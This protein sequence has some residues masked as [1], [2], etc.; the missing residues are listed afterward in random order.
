VS[1]AVLVP[2]D[3]SVERPS[4]TPTH[5]EEPARQQATKQKPQS[6]VAVPGMTHRLNVCHDHVASGRLCF[7]LCF[8]DD[9]RHSAAATILPSANADDTTCPVVRGT[10]G[11]VSQSSIRISDDSPLRAGILVFLHSSPACRSLPND[12]LWRGP[13]PQIPQNAKNRFPV[14]VRVGLGKP[15]ESDI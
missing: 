5:V 14:P 6:W 4:G 9:S 12:D 2:V 11:G 7:H 13:E 15:R 3:F 1:V 10:S 8:R